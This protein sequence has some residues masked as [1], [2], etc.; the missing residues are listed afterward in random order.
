MG[1]LLEKVCRGEAG[2][3]MFLFT[4]L[5]IHFSTMFGGIS[6]LFLLKVFW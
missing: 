3:Q 5:E 6:C 4:V 2:N 1:F